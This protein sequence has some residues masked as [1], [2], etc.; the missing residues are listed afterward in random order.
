MINQ[1]LY[2]GITKYQQAFLFFIAS[3]NDVKSELLYQKIILIF[4]TNFLKIKLLI[5]YNR[6]FKQFKFKSSKTAKKDYLHK[7]QIQHTINFKGNLKWQ[8]YY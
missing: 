4:N 5:W 7:V 6:Q 8:S 3:H 1:I 2:L